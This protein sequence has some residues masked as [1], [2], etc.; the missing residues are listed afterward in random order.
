MKPSCYKTNPYKKIGDFTHFE[1]PS[2][3]REV[4]LAWAAGYSPAYVY[5]VKGG[6][7]YGR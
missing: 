7:N 3:G 2:A 6:R 5:P 1:A 4:I